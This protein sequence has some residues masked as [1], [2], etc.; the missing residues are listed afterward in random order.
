MK[1]QLLWKAFWRYTIMTGRTILSAFQAILNMLCL[2]VA[3]ITLQ[4][5][6]LVCCFHILAWLNSLW[7]MMIPSN[8]WLVYIASSVSSDVQLWEKNSN[9]G[10][11]KPK[12]CYLVLLIFSEDQERCH[13]SPFILDLSAM[14]FPLHNIFTL[15]FYLILI[16]TWW[17]K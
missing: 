7:I 10:W 9:Q 17:C 13:S 5:Y 12:T 1:W 3:K 2:W 14:L 11:T 15:Q 6:E 4:G 16:V 8:C